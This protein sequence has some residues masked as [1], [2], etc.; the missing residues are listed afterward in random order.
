VIQAWLRERRGGV[1]RLLVPRRGE[2]RRLVELAAENARH[3][4]EEYLSRQGS[5]ERRARE[6]LSELAATVGLPLPP[7]R[8][9]AFD[10][11]TLFGREAVGSM[12][13]F[14]DGRPKRSDYRRFRIRLDAGK[15]D[16]Y[17]MMREVLER[18]LGAALTRR[19]KFIHLPDLLLV[20]G[21]KGQLGVAVDALAEVGLNLPVVALA[22]QHEELFL[23]DRSAPILLPRHSRALH[24]IQQVRDEAH[25]FAVSYHRQ[26]RDR[27]VRESVL[28]EIPGIGP[29]R[30]TAL[31]RR[32]GSVVGIGRA[33]MDELVAVPGMNRTAAEAV[34]AALRAGREG[35]DA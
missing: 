17:A 11:S 35:E 33:S 34:E 29:R 10:I 3:H 18:R 14:V 19:E 16:D 28:D 1:V 22:K 25:R 23:P 2:R 8:I 13:V 9:E 26:L 7:R 12:V 24:L 15:T 30:R 27:K 32:F 20:D 21:G 31:L 5:D 4:L 6:A